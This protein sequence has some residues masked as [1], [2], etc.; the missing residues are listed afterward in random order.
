MTPQGWQNPIHVGPGQIQT[1][2]DP[3]SLLP[4][5]MYLLRTRLE[6]QR[7][8]IKAGKD[9]YTPIQVTTEGVI[10]DGNHAVRAAAEENRLVDVLVVPYAHLAKAG[11]V[12]D[13]PVRDVP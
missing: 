3:N 7:A 11:S 8:L 12:L 5:R 10:F 1:G 4:G 9:R 6:F 13:L 2:V